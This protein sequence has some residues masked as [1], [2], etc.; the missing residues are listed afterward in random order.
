MDSYMYIFHDTEAWRGIHGVENLRRYIWIEITFNCVTECFTDMKTGL[1]QVMTWCRWSN[2]S[3]PGIMVKNI[4]GK[5]E[6]AMEH[7]TVVAHLIWMV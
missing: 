6:L 5:N 7:I 1:G 2:K 4:N 3:L